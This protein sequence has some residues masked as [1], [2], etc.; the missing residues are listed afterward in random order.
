MDKQVKMW[1]GALT[2]EEKARLCS[3][4]GLWR[5]QPVQRLR[6]P[7]LT[8]T[9][10]PHGVRYTQTD[11][12]GQLARVALFGGDSILASTKKAT[13][14]PTASAMAASWDTNLIKH[15]GE[16]IAREAKDRG[17]QLMLGPGLNLARTPLG[18]R[19]FEFFS[20]DPFLTAAM[21]IAMVQGMQDQGI[22]AVVKHFACNNTEYRRM[23]ADVIVDARTL[24]EQYL[25]AFK[26]VLQ[27]AHPAAVMGAYNKINGHFCS[28]STELLT[29]ILRKMWGYEGVVISDWASVYDR[30]KALDA[31]LDLEMPGFPL[32]DSEIE[33][34][35]RT[36]QLDVEI[37]NRS[38]E[39]I[40]NLIQAYS[41]EKRRNQPK[42]LHHGL[43]VHAASESFVLL[44]NE[45]ILPISPEKSKHI[46]LIGT[47]WNHPV[48][49][50]EGSSK[51]RPAHIDKPRTMLSDRFAAPIHVEWF[52]RVTALNEERIR[53][54]DAC[55]LLVG[56][57]EADGEGSDKKSLRLPQYQ[58]EDILEASRL[59]K[60][61]VVGIVSGAPVDISEWKD[62][63][64][65]I[66]MLWLSGE[67]MGRALADVLTG[68]VNPS[69]RLPITW[70]KNCNETGA[71]LYFPGEYDKLYY[72]ER[73]FV[74]YK[75]SLTR[76][77]EDTYPFG[78][79]LSYSEFV[80][81]DLKLD[82]AII[83]RDGCVGMEIKVKNSGS[84]A[85][86][87]TVQI[88]A[89][90][91]QPV[92]P[93]AYRH[94]VGFQKV[95]LQPGEVKWIY[96]RVNASE[97]CYY[98]ELTK[99]FELEAGTV[100]FEVGRNAR[101]ILRVGEVEAAGSYF[102]NT[103]LSKFSYLSDWLADPI[104]RELVLGTLA[105]LI[106]NQKD[107][108]DHPIIRMFKDMPLIKVVNFSGGLIGEAF[109]E[110]L[111]YEWLKRSGNTVER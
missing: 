86:K 14:F 17:V 49:Q 6:I 33:K 90:R 23:T 82:T 81:E 52:R 84:R 25:K 28:Q 40:L 51:V 79:G 87:M 20:E 26:D 85:G 107:V 89:R 95:A 57:A 72:N 74:G 15:I 32:H 9:D 50:G 45:N 22:G 103:Y 37:L 7:A 105:P 18:G 92:V 59:Q 55:I 53:Q 64:G 60:N 43:A 24:H 30:V 78:Y 36:H 13:C 65:A 88:Y 104:G 100:L 41:A 71:G 12:L 80:V 70:P 109:L 76:G 96:M 54:A 11:V 75:Y 111:E 67:G 27:K 10:G 29:N 47:L 38:V 94:L 93:S 5:T 4:M 16:A 56:G 99:R 35:V 39:R 66:L 73:I 2:L 68:V 97:L 31:G 106:S 8:L 46:I 44:K 62:K 42:R 110:H 34:A 3:G 108:L 77:I 48:I 83:H 98:N 102:S 91:L 1:M 21:G 69:G 63:V 61:T 19:N 58:T 101:D